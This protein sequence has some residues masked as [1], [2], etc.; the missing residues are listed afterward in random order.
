MPMRLWAF[1]LLALMGAVAPAN[2]LAAE[3]RSTDSSGELGSQPVNSPS[4]STS[5]LN[6]SSGNR[7]GQTVIDI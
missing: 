7:T 3:R 1:F 2:G 5:L 6:P 4:T